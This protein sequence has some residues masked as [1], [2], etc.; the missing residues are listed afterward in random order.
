MI[1][2]T[3]VFLEN[4]DILKISA[5]SEVMETVNNEPK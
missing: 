3:S 4:V 5:W 1:T 2:F